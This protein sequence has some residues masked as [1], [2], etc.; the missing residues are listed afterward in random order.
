MALVVAVVAAVAAAAVRYGDEE[1]RGDVVQTEEPAQFPTD[2]ARQRWHPHGQVDDE[3]REV[4]IPSEVLLVTVAMCNHHHFPEEERRQQAT[5]NLLRL[6]V[7]KDPS[8][9]GFD[10]PWPSRQ[11]KTK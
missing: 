5:D 1:N 9:H 10:V 3:S 8:N 7:G 11:V 6:S 4:K 2:H